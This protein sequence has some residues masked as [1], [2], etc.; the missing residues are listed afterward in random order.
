MSSFYCVEMYFWSD[1]FENV[2]FRHLKSK[3]Y[4]PT[5]RQNHLYFSH[6]VK[7]VYPQYFI[8]SDPIN[9][10]DDIHCGRI[11]SLEWILVQIFEGS[12]AT[13][14][15]RHFSS[16]CPLIDYRIF[17]VGRGEK[18]DA[19]VNGSMSLWMLSSNCSVF[20]LIQYYNHTFVNRW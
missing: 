5:Q 8:V 20:N 4:L 18:E 12:V 9:F 10:T 16:M 11:E 7:T 15:R 6:T 2:K 1:E 3:W 17:F 14:L 13:K 19:S